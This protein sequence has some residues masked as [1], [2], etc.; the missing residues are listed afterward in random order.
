VSDRDGGG[1]T[2]DAAVAGVKEAKEE[3]TETDTDNFIADILA[4]DE[5]MRREQEEQIKRVSEARRAKWAIVEEKDEEEDEEEGI[6]E[7]D[8]QMCVLYSFSDFEMCMLR[9]YQV[10]RRETNSKDQR[11]DPP[12][13]SYSIPVHRAG[14]S[15]AS[16]KTR[17]AAG[18]TKDREGRRGV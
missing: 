17:T 18:T 7:V 10:G 16:F 8:L 12:I 6:E 3:E 11:A 1:A 13:S 4:R 5:R 9:A 2:A 15:A 14:P